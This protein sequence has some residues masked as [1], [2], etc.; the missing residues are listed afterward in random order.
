[1]SKKKIHLN[2]EV[3]WNVSANAL[4]LGAAK[5]AKTDARIVRF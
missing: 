5:I 3:Y 1:M 2:F 4:G